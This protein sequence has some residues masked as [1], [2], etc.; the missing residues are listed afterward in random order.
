MGDAIPVIMIHEAFFVT[1]ISRLQDSRAAYQYW[2]E[3]MRLRRNC[4]GILW[5]MLKKVRGTFTTCMTIRL[6]ASINNSFTFQNVSVVGLWKL[7]A[8]FTNMD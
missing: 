6:E 5:L 8:P 3:K 4:T 1:C 2:S 7:G